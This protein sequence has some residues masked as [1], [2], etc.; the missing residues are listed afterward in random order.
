MSDRVGGNLTTNQPKRMVIVYQVREVIQSIQEWHW[1]VIHPGCS[2]GGNHCRQVLPAPHW[3][4]APGAPL[5][6][7]LTIVP[8]AG[9]GKFSGSGGCCLTGVSIGG[10]W[11]GVVG[12]IQLKNYLMVLKSWFVR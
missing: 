6:A 4:T 3:P 11:S 2:T 8:L 12:V 1:G 5:P 9:T 10:T 7:T